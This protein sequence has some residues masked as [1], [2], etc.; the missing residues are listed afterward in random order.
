M[1]E[2]ARMSGVNRP[3]EAAM[4]SETPTALLARVAALEETV[5]LLAGVMARY[6]QTRR[7]LEVRFAEL[8]AH[9]EARGATA[10]GRILY[11]TL[12]EQIAQLQALAGLT[13][14]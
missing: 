11:E 9:A 12:A 5:L 4:D 3:H 6:P 10:E 8:A 7:D 1:G 13:R 14:H 2:A